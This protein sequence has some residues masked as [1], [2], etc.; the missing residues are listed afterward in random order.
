MRKHCCGTG[1]KDSD[2][3]A[4]HIS[5]TLARLLEGVKVMSNEIEEKLNQIINCPDPCDDG[6][7]EIIISS[8]ET[9]KMPCPLITSDCMYGNWMEQE[10]DHHI[11]NIMSNIGVPRR[12]LENI[13]FTLQTETLSGIDKWLVR[14]FLILTGNTGSGKSFGAALAVRKY[15][16]SLINNHFDSMIWEIAE[17]AANSI[18]WCTA[19]DIN[20]DRET[21]TRAKRRYLAVIDDLGGEA[22]TPMGQ[23]ILRGVIQRRHD[24]KLPTVITTTLTM[25][26]IDIRYGRSVANRLTEDI[27]NGSM[28]IECGDISIRNTAVTFPVDRRERN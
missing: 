14:G 28:I 17:R 20:G 3:R 18:L 26:G 4:E 23:A 16:K 15:L 10:L 8:G 7:V 2:P 24:M 19:L 12:H 5:E 27:G 25:P 22:D 6:M 13:M 9:R 11:N 21:L 1:E